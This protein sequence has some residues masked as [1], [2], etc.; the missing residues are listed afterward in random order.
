MLNQKDL[1]LAL[2][3]L[4]P[5]TLASIVPTHGYKQCQSKTSNPLEGCPPRTL[6]V[7]QSDARADF[8][9]IQSAIASIPN[10]TVPYTVLI[11]PGKYT[12][13][14]NVTRQGPLTLLGMSDTPW[15]HDSY[16]EVHE[17]NRTEND[18]QIYWNSANHEE[19][20]RTMYTRVFLP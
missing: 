18:V 5:S 8:E 10:N 4:L 3:L 7:S 2:T 6:Y 14:L 19:H 17:K 20:L 15:R 11:A 13:Q 12:E 1:L 9:T 16:A